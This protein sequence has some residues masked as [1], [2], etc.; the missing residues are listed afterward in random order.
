MK[1]KELLESKKVKTGVKSEFSS[2]F[3][4]DGKIIILTTDDEKRYVVGAS[5]NNYNRFKKWVGKKTEV[6]IQRTG[7]FF[8]TKGYGKLPKINIRAVLDIEEEDEKEERVSKETV[9]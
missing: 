6:D 4:K 3:G 1:L 7:G 9:F 8:K 5:I 2:D